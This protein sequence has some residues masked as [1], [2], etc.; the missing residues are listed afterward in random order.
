MQKGDTIKKILSWT[1]LLAFILG[2]EWY[3]GWAKILQP[4]KQLSG[5][6]ILIAIVLFLSTY[7]LRTWRLYDYFNEELKGQWLLALRLI[8]LNN[9]L[10]ILLPMRS[11]EVSFPVLMKRYFS[12]EYDRSVPALF[13]F[14]L[15]DLHTI[16]SV[17]LLPVLLAKLPLF[18]A[19]LLFALWL[20][21]PLASYA[22]RGFISSRISGKGGWKRLLVKMVNGL[23]TSLWMFWKTWL[24]TLL[25]WVIKLAVLAWLLSQFISTEFY[26]RI[27]AVIGGELSSVLPFHAPGGVG[28]YE[29][30]IAAVLMPVSN[31]DHAMQAAINVHLFVLGASFI[32]AIIAWLFL[33]KHKELESK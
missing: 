5:S 22:L 27:S 17:G 6:T 8:L 16:L 18:V 15:L 12:V 24:L 25:N 33:P 14:R 26:Y 10:N 9:I 11:G 3:W 4:W 7:Q 23:P 20:S 21:I 31:A 29:A 13:W 32:G 2:V 28:T 1:V 30:G 19:L